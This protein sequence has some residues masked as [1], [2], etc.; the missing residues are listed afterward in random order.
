MIQLRMGEGG[1]WLGD[2]VRAKVSVGPE[3]L[4]GGCGRC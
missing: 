4:K 2:R 3:G 1:S